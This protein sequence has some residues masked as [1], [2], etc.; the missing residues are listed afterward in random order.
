[1]PYPL[2]FS[3][4]R[5]NS[6]LLK[7]RIVMSSM[8]TRLAGV[9]GEV[10][11]ATIAW[12]AARARGGA[13]LVTVAATFVVRVLAIQFNWSTPPLYRPDTPGE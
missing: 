5:I 11:D 4:I 6:M 13:G 8:G 2:L 7:N 3:P 10:N 1:M 9:W 12:Y